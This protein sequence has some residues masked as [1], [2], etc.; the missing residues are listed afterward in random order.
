MIRLQYYLGVL[1]AISSV[2]SALIWFYKSFILIFIIL[3][4][5]SVACIWPWGSFG[6]RKF[7]HSEIWCESLKVHFCHSHRH[8]I[9]GRTNVKLEFGKNK[10]KKLPFVHA[11][12][13]FMTRWKLHA[14]YMSSSP[15]QHNLAS[16][17]LPAFAIKLSLLCCLFLLVIFYCV[18]G[19]V[20]WIYYKL[21]N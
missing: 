19:S 3:I 16:L 1:R 5:N 17:Y 20:I 9:C 10:N 4:F 7:W 2:K 12:G 6:D 8:L 13:H 21:F 15:L 14:S 18:I 11:S